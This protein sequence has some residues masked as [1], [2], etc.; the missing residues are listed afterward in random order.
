[1]SRGG[2]AVSRLTLTSR[3]GD[4]YRIPTYL[5]EIALEFRIIPFSKDSR[6]L[7]IV[8]TYIVTSSAY[9]HGR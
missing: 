3:G 9:T 2:R 4:C 6:K 5:D 7:L 1:M 8:Q